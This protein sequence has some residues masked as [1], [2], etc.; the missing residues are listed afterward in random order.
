M[1]DQVR[2]SNMLSTWS[3]RPFAEL[4]VVLVHLHVMALN[5]QLSHWTCK[6]DSFY[7]DHE[8]FERLYVELQKDVDALAERA[9]GL[10]GAELVS[11]PLVTRQ[12]DCLAQ[13]LGPSTTIPRTDDLARRA[14]EL[15]YRI[16]NVIAFAVESLRARKMLTR[17]LDNLL[18][19]LEDR[20]ES[21][22]YLLKRRCLS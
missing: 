3:D 19:G 4:S 15:E 13:E 5:A 1:S 16:L 22:V 20:H 17:G 12:I 21:N 18:A 7:G 9:V 2:F 8:L 14:L 10:G 6:G 11:L